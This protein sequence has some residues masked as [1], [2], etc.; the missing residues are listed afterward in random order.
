VLTPED[1]D[2][3][4]TT[5]HPDVN[6]ASLGNINWPRATQLAAPQE[7]LP[8]SVASPDSAERARATVWASL[9]LTSMSQEPGTIFES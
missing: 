6:F 9:F 8:T 3:T 7:S 2:A 5:T 4:E 1:H